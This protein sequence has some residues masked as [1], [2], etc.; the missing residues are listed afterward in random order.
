[1][2]GVFCF[3]HALLESGFHFLCFSSLPA[4]SSPLQNIVIH[5]YSLPFIQNMVAEAAEANKE[6]QFLFKNPGSCPAVFMSCT[7]CQW[8]R[9]CGLAML[10]A[11]SFLPTFPPRPL[12]KAWESLNFRHRDSNLSRSGENRVYQLDSRGVVWKDPF[13]LFVFLSLSAS[14]CRSKG[15][16]QSSPL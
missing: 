2:F 11:F 6:F 1:M 14:V 16:F 13:S 4:C 3:L 9:R 8:K 12:L 7:H 10:P 5:C 15:P